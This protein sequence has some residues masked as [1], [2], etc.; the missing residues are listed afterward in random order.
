MSAPRDVPPILPMPRLDQGP[1]PAVVR[2][3]FHPIAQRFRSVSGHPF[4]LLG[5]EAEAWTA[6]GFWAEHL[7]AEDRTRVTENCLST[8]KAGKGHQ[9]DYRMTDR[10]GHDV[11]VQQVCQPVAD[12]PDDTSGF[13]P[14][15]IVEV[16]TPVDDHGDIARMTALREAL[17]KVINAD[18][19]Q[20]INMVSGY[21][22]LLERH[23]ATLGDDVGSDYAVGLRDGIEILSSTIGRLR[24]ATQGERTNMDALLAELAPDTADRAPAAKA[25]GQSDPVVA[26]APR[27]AA[28]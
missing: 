24:T 6:P 16:P 10:A 17:F 5:Y 15:H 25:N 27:S 3:D 20:P 26:V 4:Q 19:C 7:H 28:E 12:D 14:G 1:A 9:I 8:A 18:L 11:W 22:R 13:L 21:A 23:L 2:M